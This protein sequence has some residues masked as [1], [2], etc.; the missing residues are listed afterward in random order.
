[1]PWLCVLAVLVFGLPLR[2]SELRLEGQLIQGG[3]L[4]GQVAPRDAPR[5]ARLRWRSGPTGSSGSTGWRRAR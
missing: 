3:V 2:A 1:M 4:R 5:R